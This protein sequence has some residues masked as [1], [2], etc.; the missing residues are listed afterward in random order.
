MDV[1]GGLE[2]P[3]SG[4][5]AKKFPMNDVMVYELAIVISMLSPHQAR[6]K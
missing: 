2:D 6:I 3:E 4:G 5:E 1:R